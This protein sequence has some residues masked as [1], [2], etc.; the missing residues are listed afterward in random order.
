MR[1]YPSHAAFVSS[2]ALILC[3][4][5]A[6]AHM[7]DQPL[8]IAADVVLVSA[9]PPVAEVTV[10][11]PEASAWRAVRARAWS[12]S[13]EDHADAAWLRCTPVHGD[14][15][16][17]PN[18]GAPDAGT[19]WRARMRLAS[20]ETRVE[21]EAERAA[22]G[23]LRLTA[24][25]LPQA[26]AAQTPDWAKGRVWYQVFPERFRNGNPANDPSGPHEVTL[27]WT[28]PWWETTPTEIEHAWMRRFAAPRVHGYR[29]SYAAGAFST[30]VFARRYGGD[31]E[32]VTQKLDHLVNLGVDGLYLCP[33]FTSRSLHKYDAADHRHVDPTL[34][35]GGTASRGVIGAQTKIASPETADPTT[36][37]W[38][39][40]DRYFL[41][42]LLPEARKRGIRVM[43]DGVWNHVGLDHFAFADVLERGR[44][45]DYAD[46]FDIDFDTA[47]RVAGWRGWSGRNTPLPCFRQTSDGDLAPGAKQHVFDVTRRWMDPNGDGDPSDGVDGW[48]LD[49]ALEIGDAFWRDWRALVKS[50]NPDALIIAEIWDNASPWLD[51]QTFD[52]Q[53]L[54]PFADAVTAWLG[55]RPAM[56]AGDLVANLHAMFGDRPAVDAVQLTLLAS[57]DTPRL[58]SMLDNPGRD[59]DEDAG[60]T[61]AISSGFKLDAAS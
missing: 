7:T 39:A 43:L 38:T 60:T 3:W 12:P 14:A 37:T 42:T 54:Y 13:G 29:P 18:V 25:P 9:D 26:R 51:G 47:G 53:M 17:E 36:W 5:S 24:S 35:A 10:T 58:A 11:A 59:Y 44:D 8:P 31:L 50:I 61:A 52:G 40:A 21:I 28:S 4:A 30:A 56:P 46:W 1:L 55:R 20:A 16:P 32:G 19:R 34:A 49:V 33:V 48:R 22:G 41:D 2:V 57:H 27:P 45:S 6:T 23:V 15:G